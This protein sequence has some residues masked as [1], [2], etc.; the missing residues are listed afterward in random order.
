[1]LKHCLESDK[2]YLKI[3]AHPFDF[4]YVAGLLFTM[5]LCVYVFV[6][7]SFLQISVSSECLP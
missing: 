4:I 1:M 2:I 7:V 6:L 3:K 5:V